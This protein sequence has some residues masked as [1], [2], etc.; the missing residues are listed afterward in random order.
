MLSIRMN[1]HMEFSSDLKRKCEILNKVVGQRCGG[2]WSI[3]RR[4]VGEVLLHFPKNRS[5]YNF[6]CVDQCH[7][8]L[9]FI[10]SDPESKLSDK[11][12]MSREQKNRYLLEVYCLLLHW[13]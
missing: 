11:I 6:F 13:G 7:K 3:D 10:F 5:V 2:L 12:F 4:L 9:L 8:I 1:L